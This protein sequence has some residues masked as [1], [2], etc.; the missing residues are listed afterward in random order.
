MSV[1]V[2]I[3]IPT[4]YLYFVCFFNPVQNSSSG[5]TDLTSCGGD[6]KSGTKR[7]RNELK[8]G[9]H[10]PY[11]QNLILKNLKRM[12]SKTFPVKDYRMENLYAGVYLLHFPQHVAME[13][14]KVL[15]GETDDMS[16]MPY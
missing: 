8:S 1:T 10:I 2:G 16:G 7:I 4:V 15:G 14:N 6:V 9:R 12:R 5:F 11:M 13:L 3:E